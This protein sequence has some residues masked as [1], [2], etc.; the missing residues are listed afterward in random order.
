MK[1][2]FERKGRERP[3][4]RQN[5]AE[6]YRRAKGIFG[7]IEARFASQPDSK[8]PDIFHDGQHIV[9]LSHEGSQQIVDWEIVRAE[10]HLY[11]LER[12]A[13]DNEY[14]HALCTEEELLVYNT[15]N[16]AS[17]EEPQLHPRMQ[18]GREVQPA[19]L[20]GEI[21]LPTDED[22]R[23][24]RR[25]EEMPLEL[26]ERW[27]NM[28]LKTRRL[29]IDDESLLKMDNGE[30]AGALLSPWEDGTAL[31]FMKDY[32]RPK[33]DRGDIFA[34]PVDYA[35]LDRP[36]RTAESAPRGRVMPPPRRIAPSDPGKTGS[37]TG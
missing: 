35:K 25:F 7:P 20:E 3:A 29:I 34:D 37:D 22:P 30:F 9:F 21:L 10:K 26:A 18:M 2:S 32:E 4:P 1:D 15:G 12:K 13:A 5:F 6:E 33:S 16:V 24:T 14:S 31:D 11:L 19:V 23:V 28:D 8:E 27:K 36:I 17:K